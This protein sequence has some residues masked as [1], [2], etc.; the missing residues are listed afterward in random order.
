MPKGFPPSRGAQLSAKLAD[1]GFLNLAATRTM[2]RRK[3]Q[4]GTPLDEMRQYMPKIADYKGTYSY[5]V[6]P[7]A[8]A[9]KRYK[10][11][12]ICSNRANAHEARIIARQVVPNAYI[13]LTKAATVTII[14]KD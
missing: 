12:I 10:F 8:G 5:F 11:H 3:H 7:R 13:S 4:A 2:L 14:W 9:S 6:D 1:A